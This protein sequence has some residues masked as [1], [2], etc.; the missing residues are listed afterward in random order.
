MAVVF[1]CKTPENLEKCA[2]KAIELN[3]SFDLAHVLLGYYY[4]LQK[5][6]RQNNRRN[7]QSCRS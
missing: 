5:P 4:L 7:E 2:F 6:T 1:F 3:D